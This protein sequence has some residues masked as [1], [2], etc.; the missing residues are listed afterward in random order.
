MLCKSRQASCLRLEQQMVV[1][2]GAI[3]GRAQLAVCPCEGILCKG[4][5]HFCFV[6]FVHTHW[7]SQIPFLG[8]AVHC[9][10]CKHDL[11]LIRTSSFPLQAT[12]HPPH[13]ELLARAGLATLGGAGHH[14]LGLPGRG[15]QRESGGSL[16]DQGGALRSASAVCQQRGRA[17]HLEVNLQSQF[18]PSIDGCCSSSNDAARTDTW[19]DEEADAGA[20]LMER[21]GMEVLRGATEGVDAAAA[22]VYTEVL[23]MSAI[24]R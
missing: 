14:L 7:A 10:T 12:P 5:E 4:K 24:L 13:L 18:Q 9:L 19:M 23:D 20:R 22:D 3:Y 11:N 6:M 1:G 21:A 16:A 15:L 8:M 17:Q 2:L